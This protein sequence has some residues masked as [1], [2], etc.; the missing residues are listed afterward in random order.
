MTIDKYSFVHW[1]PLHSPF[2][3]KKKKLCDSVFSGFPASRLPVKYS[4]PF[5]FWTLDT[6]KK[7][8]EAS[9]LRLKTF[10][11]EMRK[12]PE[13]RLHWTVGTVVAG[14]Y[15]WPLCF[16]QIPRIKQKEPSTVNLALNPWTPNPWSEFG[17]AAKVPHSSKAFPL[18][19]RNPDRRCEGTLIRPTY[20]NDRW[21]ISV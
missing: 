13:T 18:D 19:I 16:N 11:P 6:K 21:M 12:T 8:K 15:T 20:G 7:T 2:P 3:I 14:S 1:L 4:N 10:E 9:L 17:T 5:G